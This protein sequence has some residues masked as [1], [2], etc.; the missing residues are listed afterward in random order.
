MRQSFIIALCAVSV[1]SIPVI[2]A[3][4]EGHEGGG[5]RMGL[6]MNTAG[7]KTRA[8]VEARVKTYFAAVDANK[9][10]FIVAAEAEAMRTKHRAEMGDAHFAAMDSNKDGSISRAEFDA[11]HQGGD[12][13][14]PN[15]EGESE[16]GK[17][18]GGRHGKMGD[19]MGG[20][21]MFERA[22][23]NADGKVSLAEALAKPLARFDAADTNKDGT[24]TPEERKAAR[25]TMRAK[26][27]D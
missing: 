6:G 7:P 15:A 18:R 26:W 12:H 22:D 5:H 13:Q 20:G 25:E 27:R 14:G 21:R 3:E 1:L 4:H 2:A 8:D 10:G 19:M 24:L 9:D 16:H 17:M 23:A 11:G